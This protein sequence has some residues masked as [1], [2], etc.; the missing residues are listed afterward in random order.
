MPSGSEGDTTPRLKGRPFYIT[1][2][3]PAL[4]QVGDLVL[5][6]PMSYMFMTNPVR[7]AFS[8]HA[9]WLQDE[10]VFKFV[11]RID[12]KPKYSSAVT[13]NN[14]GNQQSHMRVKSWPH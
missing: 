2:G 12:G 13:P 8:A 14:G 6:N 4:G 10:V 9:H 7:Y 3:N 11:W 5:F 1:E